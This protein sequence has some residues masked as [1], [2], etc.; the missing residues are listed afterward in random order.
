VPNLPVRTLRNF[1]GWATCPH[2]SWQGTRARTDKWRDF[3][4]VCSFY[5][6][7]VQTVR[8]Y[9]FGSSCPFANV[10]VS[11]KLFCCHQSLTECETLF[12]MVGSCTRCSVVQA[13]G[14]LHWT[15]KFV[16]QECSTCRKTFSCKSVG[17]KRDVRM[18]AR[19]CPRFVGNCDFHY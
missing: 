4:S 18:S 8:F 5:E 12:T 13:K 19:S 16:S 17:T 7:C 11:K 10:H 2:S 6:S 9:V 15:Q 14:F 3:S 1:S